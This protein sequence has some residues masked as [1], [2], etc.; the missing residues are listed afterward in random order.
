MNCKKKI[1]STEA[2]GKCPN[3]HTDYEELAYIYAFQV[4]MTDGSDRIWAQVVGQPG[5]QIFGIF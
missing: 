4:L 5:E 1:N 3:C 2:K